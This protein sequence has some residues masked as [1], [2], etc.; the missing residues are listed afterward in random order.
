MI[1]LVLNHDKY[2]ETKKIRDN[3]GGRKKKKQ[4][5]AALWS[6]DIVKCRIVQKLATFD[7]HI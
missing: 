2:L 1:L 6:D 4:H 3:S 5:R 7:C